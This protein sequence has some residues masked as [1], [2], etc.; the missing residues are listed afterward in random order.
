MSGILASPQLAMPLRNRPEHENLCQDQERA[1]L[2]LRLHGI[3]VRLLV[4]REEAAPQRRLLLLV[5][6]HRV[7][8]IMK[9]EQE[10]VWLHSPLAVGEETDFEALSGEET[11]QEINY[12]K[13]LAI[14]SI[15]ALGLEYG[16]VTIGVYSPARQKVIHVCPVSEHLRLIEQALQE[17]AEAERHEKAHPQPIMIG[18]DPEF[19]LRNREGDMVM[20]SRFFGKNG[21]VGCDAARYRGDIF[22]QQFPIAE[23]RPTPADEPGALF[24]NLYHT[25]RLAKR[26][27]TDPTLEWLAGGMPFA[28]Y[29][30]G[31]H[32]HFSGLQLSFALLRK[33]DTYL[34]LP[35]AMLEDAGCRS[36]RPRYGFLGD[37]REKAYGGFEYRT[38]PSWLVSPGIAKGVLAMA[39]VIA[40]H[41]R[42][43]RY[44]FSLDLRMQKAY[45]H[46]EKSVLAPAVQ[47]ICE[48]IRALS[49]YHRYRHDLEPF[50]AQVAAAKEWPAD[51]DFRSL[52]KL[53]P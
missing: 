19:A 20:A 16:M 11:D 3:P 38:L 22:A 33:L 36:R 21:K 35:L 29:P 7:L 27:I 43:L 48:E 5:F 30:L 31:G 41:Y 8:Q 44:D 1:L 37:F 15:Y 25:L 26:K 51:Q 9:M 45:Y 23:L 50:F 12:A 52:W 39:K 40:M 4:R 32:L 18:A 49:I 17:Y 47:R 24:R 53:N 6:G 14:R 10:S 46:G 2:L 28:G 42:M 34:T 13:F